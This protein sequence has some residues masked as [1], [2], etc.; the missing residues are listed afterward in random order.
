[1]T[2]QPYNRVSIEGARATAE[3][4]GIPSG[5][6]SQQIAYYIRPNQRGDVLIGNVLAGE[7]EFLVA[8]AIAKMREHANQAPLISG[9]LRPE[10]RVMELPVLEGTIL[11]EH[12]L[13]FK[14]LLIEKLA[15]RHGVD[16]HEVRL[17]D[18]S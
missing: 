8:L 7:S 17:G 4:E 13:E 1:M 14:K 10:F 15:A 12:V 6:G 5:E 2:V 9:S 16:G 3:L 11:E 18:A